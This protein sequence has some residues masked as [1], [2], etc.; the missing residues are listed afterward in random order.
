LLPAVLAAL[1]VAAA[2]WADTASDAETGRDL[3]NYPPDRIVD[4]LHMKLELRFEDLNERRF[5]AVETLRFAPVGRPADAVVLDAADAIRIGSI[6]LDGAPVDYRHEGDRLTLRFDP[7]L[8]VGR[9]REVVID[10]ECVEPAGSMVFTP[11]LPRAPGYGPE[12]HTTGQTASNHHWFACHDAPNE[13]LTTEL[14]VDV[15]AGLMVSSNG[16]L[17]SSRDDGRRAVWHYLQ[18]KPHVNYLVVL[19]I[20]RFDA[21]E[22]PH[23]R[24]PMEVW[25]P[26]GQGPR[27]L[28]TFGR[29]GEMIDVFERRFGHP[30]PWDRYDQVVVKNFGPGGMENTSVTTLRPDA[31]HDAVALADDDLEGLIAHEL[32]HQ[33]AGDFFTCKSW[34]HIWLNEGWATFGAAL[35]FEHRDGQDGYLDAMRRS[36][37]RVVN[38]D[39]TTNDQPMVSAVY[40]HPWETFGRAANPYA[41]GASIL[42]MLRMMLGDVVFFEGLSRF[43]H[44]HALDVVET[45][46]LRYAME[47]VSGLGLEWFFDQWCYR[48]GV[49]RLDVTVSYDAGDGALQ[50]DVEQT[51]HIDDRTPAF[52]FVL[53]VH[54]ETA[55]GSRALTLDVRERTATLRADLDGPPTMVAI[56]P[57]MHVLMVADVDKPRRLWM[58]QARRGPTISARHDALAALSARSIPKVIDLLAAIAADET[59]RHTLRVSAVRALTRLDSRRSRSA[60]LDLG[61]ADIDDARVRAAVVTALEDLPARQVTDRLAEVAATDPSYATRAAA[62]DALAAHEAREHAS[63]VADLAHVT[64]QYDQVRTAALEALIAFDDPRGLDLGIRYSAYGEPDRSRPVAIRAV[65]RLAH[66]DRDRAVA[67]LIAL[68]DDPERRSVAAAGSALARLG[69]P[70]AVDA[71]RALSETHPSPRLRRQARRW[72]AELTP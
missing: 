61:N 56:D 34:S 8:A 38:R 42:H 28:Q 22:I 5:T 68:L 20:G 10:Y 52:R 64:S 43:T 40:E 54:V 30:Y 72:L 14:I 41:K 36:F 44:R 48:P 65:G 18:D 27:V 62:I 29:T 63:L 7:P 66:H 21:V 33:W 71:V 53:P 39:R 24:V 45:N 4:H 19:V 58:E 35:W 37:R 3:R 57:E 2:G 1:A 70:R 59:T 9:A 31:V 12:V 11:R 51:Q 13:R 60:L 16:H 46:D 47:A 69:D 67:H 50:V 6:T 17:V 15:P 32:A 55:S 49:P 25:V 23:P 26:P